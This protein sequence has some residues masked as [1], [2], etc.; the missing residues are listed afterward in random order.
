MRVR[1][2]VSTFHTPNY[3]IWAKSDEKCLQNAL[4]TNF[5][6]F[7]NLRLGSID[8]ISPNE[9]LGR[10]WTPISIVAHGTLDSLSIRNAGSMCIVASATCCSQD[11][12][13]KVGRPEVGRSEVGRSEV[14]RL[15]PHR[16]PLPNQAPDRHRQRRGRGR[17]RR[18]TRPNAATK[19]FVPMHAAGGASRLR[20]LSSHVGTARA[21]RRTRP[22]T[23]HPSS[24]CW[25]TGL[26]LPS[27]FECETL[28]C[29]RRRTTGMRKTSS[30][31][32]RRRVPTEKLDYDIR[33]SALQATFVSTAPSCRRRL[34][35]R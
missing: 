22:H 5:S 8:C 31:R 25:S 24:T 18:S 12:R 34:D 15:G 9:D 1:P 16:A 7:P 11:G 28:C 23:I 13:S 17:C 10:Q 4:P 2:F 30:L 33:D 3:S 35:V 6:T 21:S 32:S 26:P 20:A 27:K 29:F 19:R 14:G